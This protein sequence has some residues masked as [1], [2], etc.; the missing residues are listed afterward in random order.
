MDESDGTFRI[1]TTAVS[2]G[3]GVYVYEQ[4]DDQLITV[5]SVEN[6]APDERIYSVRFAPDRAY[7][8]TF[9]NVDPL[10]VIDL[11]HPSDPKLMGELKV[12]G[13]S[14]YLHIV[15][16]DHVLGI[17]RDSNPEDGQFGAL[18]IS[19]FD[20]N[21]PMNPRLQDRYEFGG[22]RTTFPAIAPDSPW[23]L[24]DHHAVSYFAGSRILALPVYTS[25]L[26]RDDPTP[27][28]FEDPNRSAVFTFKIDTDHVIKPIDRI[29]FDSRADRTVRIGK[30]LY[31]MSSSELKVTELTSGTGEVIASLTFENRGTDD[32]VR[33]LAGVPM[34]AD[35]TGNDGQLFDPESRCKIIDMELLSGMGEMELTEDGSGIKYT[36][37]AGMVGQHR[38]RYR[39]TDETGRESE[40]VLTVESHWDWHNRH[41]AKD[42]D[43]NGEVN[44]TD[45]LHILN[46]IA[47]HGAVDTAAYDAVFGTGALL[48]RPAEKVEGMRHFD[49]N[50]DGKIGPHDALLVLN[51]LGGN[52]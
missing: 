9:R 22:G 29:E 20:I 45:A 51:R 48:E 34:V 32:F 24:T 27:P 2:S 5:G 6:M 11:T 41:S 14:Q 19:L 17:G 26:W 16:P 46:A 7:V 25:W 42:V 3:T 8:V 30:H 21:D 4:Y 12:P 33:M 49:V 31:S 39:M 10:F 44:P 52:Q 15:G 28:L 40:A 1:A 35:V 43:A 37:S 18:V 47:R 50:N 13:Y 23:T 36:P 38:I